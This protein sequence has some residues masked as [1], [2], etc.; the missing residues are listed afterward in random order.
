LIR[1]FV[2]LTQTGRILECQR[3]S[4]HISY[5]CFDRLSQNLYKTLGLMNLPK[6]F[7]PPPIKVSHSLGSWI[8]LLS[9]WCYVKVFIYQ[10]SLFLVSFLARL[11]KGNV[12]FCHH[13]ASVVYRPLTFHILIFSSETP[14][15]NEVKL[16]RKHLWKVLSK[17]CS[18]CPDPLTNMAAI[19]NFC[20]WLADLKKSSPLKLLGQMNW[21]LVG[22]IYG[23]SSIND[24]H[25]VPIC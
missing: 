15:P 23:R 11:A 21:N 2:Y 7:L 19:D 24:A 22:S 8:V 14:Q 17:D 13:L 3:L 12:S 4:I 6:I 25:F 1:V 10:F 18:F 20:F 16:G 5:D 9:L